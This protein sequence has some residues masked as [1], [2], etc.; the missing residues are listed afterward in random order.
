[1]LI[2]ASTGV[3]GSVSNQQA[4]GLA[5]KVVSD[6]SL[7]ENDEK[8]KNDVFLVIGRDYPSSNISILP[9]TGNG[10]FGAA[11]NFTAGIGVSS[12]AVADFN[13][14]ENVDLAVTNNN[15]F[16]VSIL[17]GTGT[18][19]FGAPTNFA[20]GPLPH[21]ITVVH[22]TDPEN[23]DDHDDDG[24]TDNVD[25]CPLPN[26]DQADS[27]GDRIGDVCD[28]PGDEC[29]SDNLL[30]LVSITSLLNG[31]SNANTPSGHRS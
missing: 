26:P 31:E 5:T 3:L 29:D 12:V 1:M 2:I 20:V 17:L 4:V 27:D 13:E 8:S 7:A 18:G 11:T 6:T 23:N 21:S 24:I 30:S 25:N 22:E 19:S 15:S 14:D 10:S 9:G 28:T 16:D